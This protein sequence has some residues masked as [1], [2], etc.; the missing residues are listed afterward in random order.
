M[1]NCVDSLQFLIC[2][3]FL[4][5]ILLYT[6]R[7]CVS[8][9]DC[10]AQSTFNSIWSIISINITTNNYHH[11]HQWRKCKK[12]FVFYFVSSSFWWRKEIKGMMSEENKRWFI[13][14]SWI[15]VV[16]NIINLNHNNNN[17]VARYNLAIIWNYWRCLNSH[18]QKNLVFLIPISHW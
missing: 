3:Q 10:T 12:F 9:F 6:S 18:M 4:S 17:Y 11:Q 5:G 2:M 7:Y 13:C 15:C 16:K 1:F 14:I 8:S